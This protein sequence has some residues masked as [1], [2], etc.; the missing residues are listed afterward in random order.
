MHITNVISEQQHE[1]IEV[2]CEGLRLIGSYEEGGWTYTFGL[3]FWRSKL[4]GR[5]AVE[6]VAL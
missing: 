3:P 2:K 6:C 5:F 4:V 1:P